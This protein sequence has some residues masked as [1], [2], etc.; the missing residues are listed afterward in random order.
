[1]FFNQKENRDLI[2]NFETL[3]NNFIKLTKIKYL[4]SKNIYSP[5]D[6]FFFFFS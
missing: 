5:K 3:E 1:M 4:N 2:I 6:K